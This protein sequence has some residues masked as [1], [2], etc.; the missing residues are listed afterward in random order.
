MFSTLLIPLGEV[1]PEQSGQFAGQAVMLICMLAGT[2][3]CWNISR[4]PTTNRKCVLS[5]MLVLASMGGFGCVG[6]VVKAT[7]LSSNSRVL[8]GV[9]GMVMFGLMITALVLAILGLIEY[10]K[11]KDLYV[12]GKRQAIWAIFISILMLCFAGRA[13]VNGLR[14]SAMGGVKQIS[15]QPGKMLEFAN[16]NFRFRSPERPWVPIDVSK[17]N[18]DSRLSFT[19]RFPEAYFLIIPEVLGSDIPMSSEQNAQ[20]GKSHIESVASSVRIIQESSLRVNNLEGRLVEL[21]ATLG[22]YQLFYVQWYLATNGYSYQLM[23]YGKADDRTH[24]ESELKQMLS[25]FEVIDPLRLAPSKANAFTNNFISPLHHYTV[26]VANSAWHEFKTL[27]EDFPEAEFG[28]SQG[29]SCFAVLPVWLG[30]GRI[31][32]DALT[33]GLLATVNVKYPDDDLTHR[34][35]INEN[36]Y[37]GLQFDYNRKVEGKT[38]RYRARVIYAGEFGYMTVA[39]TLRNEESVDAILNDALARVK[40]ATLQSGATSGKFQLGGQDQKNQAFVLNQAGL[41]HFNAGEYEKALP[42]FRAAIATE[43]T[44]TIRIE[45]LLLTWC[46]LGRPKEGLDYLVSQP[47][48]VLEKPS[49]RAYLAYLQSRCSLTDE[50]ITN[51]AKVF[52]DGYRNEDDFK[53]YINLL[54]T[55]RQYDKGLAEVEQYLKSEDTV[56]VRLLT[57]EILRGKKDYDKAVDFLKTEHNKAPYNSKITR[58][59]V[60]ALLDAGKPNEGLVFCRELLKDDST[61]YAA[62]YLKAR[63]EL[64]LKWYREAKSSL[65][66]AAKL[67]PTNEDVKSE[68]TYV[69]GLLGEGNN[70]M[71]KDPIDPVLLPADFTNRV[72]D[73]P[74]KG[75][76]KDFGAYLSRFIRALA[77]KPHAEY[78]ITDYMDIEVLDAAG[79]AAYSTFQTSFDPLSEDIF[80]NEGRVLDGS[81]KVLA[82]IKSSDCYVIDDVYSGKASHKMIL[83]VPIAGLQPGCKLSLV[84]TRRTAGHLEEFPFLSHCF[85]RPFPVLESGVFVRGDGAGLTMRST[86]GIKREALKEGIYW[87]TNNPMVARWEPLQPQAPTF[88]PMLWIADDARQWPGLV[89]NYLAT[90]KDQ[91]QTDESLQLKALQLVENLPGI[92]SKVSVL[93]RFVQTNCIYKALEFGRHSDIPNKAA[94]TLRKSYGDCKDHA[95]LLQQLLKC[96]GIPASL[97]LVSCQRPVQMDLPSLDQF[98]HMIVAI[99]QDGGERF[100]DCTDKGSD[101]TAALPAGLAEHTVLVLDPANPHLAKLAAYPDNA[102]GMEVQQRVRLSGTADLSVD[103]T[104]SLTGVSAA[105]LRDYLQGLSPTFRQEI[106]QRDMDMADVSMSHFEVV[107]LDAPD[108]PLE[109][110]YSFILKNRFHQTQD[111][112]VGMLRA[113]FERYYLSTAPAASRLTPFETTLPIKIHSQVVFDLPAGYHVVEKSESERKFDSRFITFQSHKQMEGGSLKLDYQYQQVVGKFNAA[114]YSSFQESHEQVQS[115][116]DHEVVL[117]TDGR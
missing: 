74:P 27:K 56:G 101:L 75:Y 49:I 39:W 103:E 95:V 83:N 37:P 85:S 87:S 24:I 7:V 35:A 1:T 97:T 116:I 42:L 96:V 77:Y 17:I 69:S 32:L 9:M 28:G 107:A 10:S 76:A 47:K 29:D 71:L 99:P 106:L 48:E 43:S 63:C 22:N 108:R 21:E 41:Y 31:D 82:P 102:S 44:N 25:R 54:T 80:M 46:R 52:S 23:G 65:E 92:P 58:N 72:A 19:R 13:Y 6:M 117:R 109:L 50:A 45:N 90:I 5:L 81:G 110:K 93:S 8:V 15:G 78:K 55:T 20:I 111:G 61:S 100:I 51:Y 67:E 94:D 34:Q 84:I 70:S 88:L 36:G 105:Y 115:L 73:V 12:Q 89:T 86:P 14:T 30:D 3:K 112:L 113:G 57:A 11:Q 2:L 62:H 104:L 60:N 79:V 40:I 33:A 66:E 26:E 68:L 53:E 38:F 91:L 114:D 18:K 16:Y 98:D 4:R 64:N 59:L